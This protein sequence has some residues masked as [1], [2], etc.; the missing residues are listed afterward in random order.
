MDSP[1]SHYID[2][3]LHTHRG[4][5]NGVSSNAKPLYLLAIIKGIEEGIITENKFLY[6]EAME[7]LYN[8]TC[9]F[10]EYNKL[11][12]PFF[13]PFFHMASDPYYF[14]K[15]KDGVEVPKASRTP[16]GKFLRENTKY[17]YLDQALWEEME[18]L[19][20]RE[21]IKDAIIT[22]LIHD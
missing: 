8:D 14:I 6:S 4:T 1:T 3:I 2:L 22:N 16:S 13:K 10:Y 12:T 21:A 5:K 15:W 20:H 18:D 17:A 9:R 11:L 7:S 19:F